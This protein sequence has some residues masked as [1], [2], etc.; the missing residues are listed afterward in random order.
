MQN[1]VNSGLTSALGGS[2]PHEIIANKIVKDVIAKFQGSSNEDVKNPGTQN[3]IFSYIQG[4]ID[5]QLGGK[6]SQE[7]NQVK[8]I[9]IQQAKKLLSS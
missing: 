3:K 5:K 8:E 7:V 4:E 6:D 9:A 1:I 2:N